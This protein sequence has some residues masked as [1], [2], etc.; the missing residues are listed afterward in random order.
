MSPDAATRIKAVREIREQL[1]RT[2]LN[3]EAAQK[4]VKFDAGSHTTDLKKAA[5]I[6]RDLPSKEE[7]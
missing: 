4:Y 7:V 1:R 2:G 6:L 3:Y 5:L